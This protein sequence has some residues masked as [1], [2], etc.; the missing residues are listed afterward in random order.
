M[1][2]PYKAENEKQ[3]LD[4]NVCSLLMAYA[5]GASASLQDRLMMVREKSTPSTDLSK[6]ADAHFT[7]VC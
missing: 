1:T 3:S 6:N 2:R 7:K 5:I 4:C